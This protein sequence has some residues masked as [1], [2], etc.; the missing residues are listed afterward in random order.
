MPL[1]EIHAPVYIKGKYATPWYSSGHSFRLY[2]ETGCSWTEGLS[3]DES[4][5]RLAQGGAD[6]ASVA[7][8][9]NSVFTRA[10]GYLKAGTT[11]TEL[12]LYESA[13]GG[14]DTLIHLND[15]PEGNTYGSSADATA[16]SF[17]MWVMATGLR[18]KWR[19]TLFDGVASAPQK[20]PPEATPSGDNGTL[21]WYFVRSNIPFATNDGLRLTRMVSANR[22]YNRKLARTYGRVVNP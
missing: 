13:T 12:A 7:S 19:F 1:N 9:V 18:E 15:L 10:A 21:A 20:Y 4:N 8:I 22:G 2:F 14:A 5:Y 11:I 16:S 17:W 3:G 6:I